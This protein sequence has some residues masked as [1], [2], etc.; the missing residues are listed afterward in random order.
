MHLGCGQWLDTTNDILQLCL[1]MKPH[2]L[3]KVQVQGSRHHSLHPLGVETY[4]NVPLSQSGPRTLRRKATW[5]SLAI[6]ALLRFRNCTP[7]QTTKANICSQT[8]E[9]LKLYT[10]LK[11]EMDRMFFFNIFSPQYNILHLFSH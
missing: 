9:Q 7:P 5:K 3:R 4:H 2:H 10:Y 8:K 6:S 11:P 1:K